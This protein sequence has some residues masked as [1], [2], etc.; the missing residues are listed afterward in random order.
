[1]K[2]EETVKLITQP[3][4]EN[5][6]QK[7]NNNTKSQGHRV[8]HRP[9]AQW[10]IRR[11]FCV[12]IYVVTFWKLRKR[13]WFSNEEVEIKFFFLI[14]NLCFPKKETKDWNHLSPL[15]THTHKAQVAPVK[16]ISHDEKKKVYQNRWKSCK[17][18][19]QS[20]VTLEYGHNNPNQM[21]SPPP[22][23]TQVKDNRMFLHHIRYDHACNHPEF[24]IFIE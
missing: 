11:K 13:G 3:L 22:N 21:T 16:P 19:T 6:N 9:G 10:T 2:S 4:F 24:I 5:R 18:R 8:P 12:Q 17:H 15:H 7:H 20:E 1:M 14:I 23:K